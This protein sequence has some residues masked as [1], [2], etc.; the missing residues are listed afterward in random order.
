LRRKNRSIHLQVLDVVHPAPEG[1]DVGRHRGGIDALSGDKR[2]VLSLVVRDFDGPVKDD[3]QAILV[4]GLAEGLVNGG[5]GVDDQLVELRI[6]D[7]IVV[8]AA[9]FRNVL[10]VVDLVH[11]GIGRGLPGGGP[12]LHG[13]GV[14]AVP[15][16]VAVG[17]VVDFQRDADGGQRVLGVGQNAVGGMVAAAVSRN[18]DFVGHGSTGGSRSELLGG[19]VPGVAGGLEEAD[20]GLQGRVVLLL[21]GHVARVEI[22]AVDVLGERDRIALVGGLG[23]RPGGVG[24]RVLD[25]VGE[26]AVVGVDDGVAV[27]G[28]QGGDALAEILGLVGAGVVADLDEVGVDAEVAV[29]EV[30]DGVDRVDVAVELAV[31]VV[32]LDRGD[33]VGVEGVVGGQIIGAGGDTGQHIGSGGLL[34]EDGL[35]L[36][37]AEE[38]VFVGFQGDSAVLIG[39]ELVRAGALGDGADSLH[40]GQ[41]ALGEAELVRVEVVVRGIAVVIQRGDDHGQLI[42][43]GGIDLRHVEGHAVIAGLLDAGDI[44]GAFAGLDAGGELGRVVAQIAVDG[45]KEVDG[46]LLGGVGGGKVAVVGGLDGLPAILRGGVLGDVRIVPKIHGLAHGGGT[47]VLAGLKNTVDKVNAG[48]VDGSPVLVVLVLGEEGR[49][50]VVAAVGDDEVRHGLHAGAV[51]LH[52][53]DRKGVHGSGSVIGRVAVDV[54]AEDDVVDGDRRAVFELGVIADGDVIIDGAVVVLDNV[55]VAEAV[56]GVIRAVVRTGLALDALEDNVAFA[57][58][59]QKRQTVH[60]VGN[61]HVVCGGFEEGGEL[62][63]EVAGRDDKRVVLGLFGGG[64][65]AGAGG[66]RSARAGGS[67]RR[68]AGRLFSLLGAAGENGKRHN[69]GQQQRYQ[70]CGGCFHFF[71]S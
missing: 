65:S 53:F 8:G 20:G 13:A 66:C 54:H 27:D 51:I 56:V 49:G 70:S 52:A 26:I 29:A 61:V 64:G 18:D 4:G 50:G 34:E 1:G 5:A 43:G 23:S 32:A 42:D 59:V 57:V 62:L 15:Q 38:V 16:D 41:I 2:R 71:P 67:R 68:G 7:V 60:V 21:V 14:E 28:Q 44:V 46:S 63:R 19:V 12:H 58:G 3:V 30:V 17:D 9:V 45:V 6:L 24:D 35:D 33:G 47:V 37:A 10:G 69:E 36:R 39:D 22:L 31:G 48:L 25:D 40:R 11:I 55:A